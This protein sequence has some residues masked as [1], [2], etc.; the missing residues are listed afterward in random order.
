[1]RISTDG[2]E[3]G[4]T[5]LEALVA[6]VIIS[7]GLTGLIGLQTASLK[8]TQ[9]SAAQTQATVAMQSMVS[10]I[11]ANKADAARI[12]NH[13]AGKSTASVPSQ[14]CSSSCTPR[15]VAAH[16]LHQWAES[17]A[18]TLPSG[19]GSI[20]SIGDAGTPPYRFRITIAWHLNKINYQNSGSSDDVTNSCSARKTYCM[21]RRVTL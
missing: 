6:I 7:I 19:E 9:T 16:D 3:D 18:R 8:N 4:F 1:M 5:L 15:Q 2:F 12:N 13:Y 21:T 17:L 14:D 11:R 20:E 10:R